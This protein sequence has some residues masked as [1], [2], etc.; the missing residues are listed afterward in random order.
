[1]L[2]LGPIANV[3][4]TAQPPVQAQASASEAMKAV[5]DTEIQAPVPPPPAKGGEPGMGEHLDFYDTEMA[6]HA[7]QAEAQVSSAK[8]ADA[9]D[10]EAKKEKERAKLDLL[11][12]GTGLPQPTTE[13][14]QVEL[15]FLRPLGQAP[16]AQSSL[17][18]SIDALI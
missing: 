1:M 13:P 17:G 7:A 8:T 16:P 2:E 5:P 12:K 11:G 9:K 14:M 3:L 10:T 4:K 15:P 6:R 18:Q